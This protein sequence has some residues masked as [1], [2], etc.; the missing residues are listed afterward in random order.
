MIPTKAKTLI[1]GLGNPIL[2][3]DGIGIW[4][5]RAV[6]EALPSDA[7]VDIREL[8]VGGLTLMEHM[9]G[10]ERVILIDAI[11]TQDGEPGTVR[12]LTL[13]QL[14]G[15]LNTASSHDVSLPLALEAGRRLDAALPPDEAIHIV[16][17]EALE[18]LGFNDA[19]TEPVAAA[20]PVAVQT[21][22]SILGQWEAD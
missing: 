6:R 10:Y 12:R 8:S 11:M 13:S 3:D 9:I 15:T 5:A 4:V 18:V 1:I 7:D 19:C 2:T 21:V 17:I 16:A 22:L 14:G 20:I